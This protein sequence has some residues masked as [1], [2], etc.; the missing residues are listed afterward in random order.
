L[1]FIRKLI[2][3]KCLQKSVAKVGCMDLIDKQIIFELF[4]NCR[5]T[6]RSLSKKL[7]LSSTS[8][9]KRVMKLR[10]SGLISR[11]YV[12][13]SLAMLDAEHCFA[14]TWRFHEDSR[15]S[16]PKTYAEVAMQPNSVPLCDLIMNCVK[17]C[18]KG[19]APGGAIRKIKK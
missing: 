18:P 17:A 1:G 8:I 6:Y 16:D 13:L 7:G 19:V 10:E 4:G 12:L 14:K 5:A 15:A 3:S 2:L 11:G 9:R